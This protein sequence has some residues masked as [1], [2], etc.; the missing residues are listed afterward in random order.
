MRRLSALTLLVFVGAAA[1]AHAA[2]PELDDA[3]LRYEG[4]DFEGA[5]EA[6][7][8][9]ERGQGLDRAELLRLIATRAL[10]H[11]ALGRSDALDRDLVML[12]SL[13]PEYDLGRRAPPAVSD[14]FEAA[15]R[16]L[17]GRLALRVE[18]APA[19][20][21]VRVRAEVEHDAAGLVRTLSISGRRPGGPWRTAAGGTVDIGVADGVVEVWAVARGPGGAPVANAGSVEAP[22]RLSAPAA[23]PRGR[24]SSGGNAALWIGLGIGAAVAAVATT[25]LVVVTS[26]GDGDTLVGS[27]RFE[28]GIP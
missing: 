12:V 18:S 26:S 10:V 14:A 22:L 4:A 11:F 15:R 1:T 13:E 5:L 20:G 23:A 28:R 6:L 19:P 21:G 17:R 7:G 2:S 24:P 27:P 8:R 3:V 16:R 9:A 25:V